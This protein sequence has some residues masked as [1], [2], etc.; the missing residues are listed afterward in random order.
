LPAGNEEA[1]ALC[2]FGLQNI[3]FTFVWTLDLEEFYCERICDRQPCSTFVVPKPDCLPKPLLKLLLNVI[4]YQLVCVAMHRKPRQPIEMANRIALLADFP[5]LRALFKSCPSE[6]PSSSRPAPEEM[7]PPIGLTVLAVA[8]QSSPCP[9]NAA[10]LIVV[11]AEGRQTNM[12]EAAN[13]HP[14]VG[15]NQGPIDR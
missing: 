11:A 14:A 9:L 12:R 2:Q 10:Q 6:V 8:D 5:G 7:Q 15:R 3:T 4:K 1:L 13:L